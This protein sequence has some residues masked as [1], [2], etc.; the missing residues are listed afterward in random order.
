MSAVT[1]ENARAALA[2]SST[3]AVVGSEIMCG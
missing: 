3:A 2:S 1:A